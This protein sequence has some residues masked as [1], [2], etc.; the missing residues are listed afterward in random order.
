MS[1]SFITRCFPRNR[2][3]ILAALGAIIAIPALAADVPVDQV[4]Q[5]FSPNTISV[6][7]GDTIHFKNGDDVTHNIQ[8]TNPDDDNDDKGLQKPGE[9]IAQLFDKAG[10]YT[11]HCAIHPRMKMIVDVKP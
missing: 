8:V 2:L 5:K 1:T 9:E 7:V 4:G 10:T 6:K 11:I 3:A